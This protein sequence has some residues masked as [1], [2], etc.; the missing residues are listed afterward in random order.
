MANRRMFSNSII[1][2]ARFLQ[3][4]ATTRL[5][6]YDLGMKADDEGFVEAFSVLR[7]TCASED[8]L[9]LLDAKGY[10]RVIN[11][12]FLTYI[13]DWEV[14]N[15]IR[16]D[17][18][19]ESVYHDLKPSVTQTETCCKPNVNQLTTK[20]KPSVTQ[21]ETCGCHSIVE[22]SIGKNSKGKY[23]TG[24][25]ASDSFE[26]FWQAY[27]KKKNKLDAQKAFAKVKVPLDTLL[28]AI[29]R[30]KKSAQWQKEGGQYIPYPATWLN[31]GAWEDEVERQKN[32]IPDEKDYYEGWERFL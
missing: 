5:L 32:A 1:N 8:D 10:I 29:E 22:D 15:K 27:P 24:K 26:K 12:D 25:S 31:R 4:P 21:T 13:L 2:S 9:R 6:Y 19:Q 11:D 30:Q 3:M 16:K 14:N 20:V 28:D 17:R 23:S 18:F 7:M